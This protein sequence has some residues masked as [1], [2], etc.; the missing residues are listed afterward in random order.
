M[1]TPTVS[2]GTETFGGQS[3]GARGMH[4]SKRSVAAAMVVI[5]ALAIAAPITG[6]SAATT[7]GPLAGWGTSGALSGWDPAFTGLA[8]PFVPVVAGAPA[9]FG[10]D[11]F[12][13]GGTYVSDVVN[14]AT[15]VQ[16]ANGGAF[17]LIG[18]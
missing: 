12:S 11:G 18:P 2:A 10:G 4:P 16:V 6:A 5:G 9:V 7:P 1:P 8:A 3:K 17:S 13:Y 15:V 14:G